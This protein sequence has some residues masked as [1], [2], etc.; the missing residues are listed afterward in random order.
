LNFV[1][2]RTNA[3]GRLRY[4]SS[5]YGFPV[6]TSQEKEIVFDELTKIRTKGN[7]IEAEYR[8]EPTISFASAR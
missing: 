3:R 5:Y 1:Q 6:M 8:D 4:T 2:E 7:I